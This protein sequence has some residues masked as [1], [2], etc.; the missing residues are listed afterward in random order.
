MY[1]ALIRQP[2]NYSSLL[3][4]QASVD[5]VVVQVGAVPQVAEGRASVAVDTEYTAIPVQPFEE[6]V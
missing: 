1:C 2:I 6:A 4:A 3:P 5:K